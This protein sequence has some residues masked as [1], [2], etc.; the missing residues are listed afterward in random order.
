MLILSASVG[1]LAWAMRRRATVKTQTEAAARLAETRSASNE[2]PAVEKLLSV[3]TLELEVGYGLVRLVDQQ[4][5]GDLLDRISAMRRQLAVELGLIVPPVRIR[6]NMQLA[7]HA[8][9]IKIRGNAVAGGE[10]HPGQYLAMD[11]GIASGAIDGQAT[12]EPAFGLAAWWIDTGQKQRAE[13]LNYTVV[14]ASSVLAT[15]ITEVIKTHADE[16]LSRTETANLLE[17]LKEKAPKLVEDAVP[18]IIKPGELQKVLQALLRERV[19]IRD[20][21]SIVETLADWGTRTKDLDVLTE[22]VRN[23]LRRTICNQYVETDA[24]TGIHRLFCVTLDPAMEDLVNGYVERGPGGTSMSMP[25]SVANRVTA[26][27]VKEMQKLIG[28]GHQPVVLTSPQVRAQVRQLLEPHL[29]AAAVLG[30]NEVSKGVEV[31]SMGL[32]QADMA[33]ERTELEGALN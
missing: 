19:P 16:L 27:V 28:A 13:T 1:G 31:E 12:R 17:Q 11:S 30:Y 10:V 8:Y 4:Q 25:P 21:E 29:P 7:P 22:Y 18:E 32:A 6:D 33:A 2:P 15:H 26:A 23:A 5:G 3:D 14:D 24:E 9:R 20:M